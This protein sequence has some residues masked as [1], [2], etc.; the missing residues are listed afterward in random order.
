MQ[1]P[2]QQTRR[3]VQVNMI[4]QIGPVNAW[5]VGQPPGHYMR[6][7]TPAGPSG[8]RQYQRVDP[9]TGAVDPRIIGD[10]RDQQRYRVIT[11]ATT[12]EKTG[13]K[14]RL[15]ALPHFV[16]L[17]AEDYPEFDQCTI[18]MGDYQLGQKIV[19]LKCK[20]HFDRDCIA[21][22]LEERTTCPLC[23]KEV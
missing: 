12:V 3:P 17:Q 20:H 10:P 6:L 4:G 14:Y 2:V 15:D 21:K 13:S 16:K 23:K 18:C 8:E 9:V 11:V 22:W 19:R 7:V 5:P 1:P